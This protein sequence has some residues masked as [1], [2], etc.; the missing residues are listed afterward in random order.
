MPGELLS[1]H[2]EN[3]EQESCRRKKETRAEARDRRLF[4]KRITSALLPGSPR[5]PGIHS[6]A[7]YAEP[8]E[9]DELEDKPDNKEYHG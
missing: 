1:K 8:G 3:M 7:L 2:N 4:Y 9:D 5:L 6:S